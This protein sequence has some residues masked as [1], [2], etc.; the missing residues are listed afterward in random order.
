MHQ[1][2]YL[3]GLENLQAQTLIKRVNYLNINQPVQTAAV[4]GVFSPFEG[5]IN[6]GYPQ[7]LTFYLQ[8][9]KEI[10]KETDKLGI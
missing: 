3:Y 2:I 1:I 7:K 6:P 8:E 9:T 5:N 4:N 10:D